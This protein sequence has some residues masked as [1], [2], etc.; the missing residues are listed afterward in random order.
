LG[1]LLTVVVAMGT[2]AWGAVAPA[3]ADSSQN[4]RKPHHLNHVFVIVLENYKTEDVTAAASPYLFG[5]TQTGVT[6]DEMY[7]VD[8]ASLS[9]YVAMTSG[10]T[11]NASTKADCFQYDCIFEP[12][13]DRNIGDQ[14]EETGRTWK[15]YM[16]S[17]PAPCTHPTVS[18]ALDPYLVGY[19]TRH[20]PFMYYRDIV[21]PDISVRP[22][23]C[24]DHDVPLTQLSTDLGQRDLPNY[25]LIVPNTCNDAHDRGAGCSLPTAD[26]WL[27]AN[28]P[29][30]LASKDFGKDGALI[31]TFD[32]SEG[33]DVRGCCGN[34]VGGKIFTSVISRAV[35]NPGGHT[36]TQY[37]HYSV[38]RTIEDNFG[39]DCLGHACDPGIQPFGTDVWQVR[40]RHH[41]T[42]HDPD[43]H[44]A[45]AH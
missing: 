45:P 36:A 5:L 42:P 37:N 20:N 39:V 32:E 2:V 1:V 38:L 3:G 30:I 35:T 16:E 26:A 18:G 13:A 6:L 10:N 11:P 9:N 21:G 43:G 24:V 41:R 23:R 12:P 34:A 31:I 22:P 29:A 17:M 33:A 14:L 19:A 25:A 7:G 28:V 4:W 27:A 8:H 40:N 44:K 15:A